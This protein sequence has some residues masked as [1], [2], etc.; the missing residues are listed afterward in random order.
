MPP[1]VVIARRP[2]EI[3]APSSWL[4]PVE[5]QRAERLLRETD[6][7]AYVAAHLLVRLA[8]AAC[9][10][11]DPALLTLRQ[12]CA[13]HGPGHGKPYLEEFPGLSVSLSHT[14]GYVSAAAGPG[15]VGVDVERVPPGPLN[16]ALAAAVAA[17]GERVRDS[18][19]LIRLWVRKE[20]LIKRGEL[21]LD[22]MRTRPWRASG[23]LLEWESADDV[24]G[25]AITDR[26]ARR[27]P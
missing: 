19:E 1:T 14:R 2:E 21:T 26:P 18:R 23:H 9:L 20:A 5:R 16:E 17:P 22:D 13:T 6:R 7:R 24:L 8:A 3:D 15:R 4:T 10:E 25:T 11:T 27:I 12:H